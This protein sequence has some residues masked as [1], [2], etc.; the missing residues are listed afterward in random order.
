[1]VSA[2]LSLCCAVLGAFWV[3]G[4]LIKSKGSVTDV[5][6][7]LWAKP[8][9]RTPFT[10]LFAASGELQ[11][12]SF[13]LLCVVGYF[14]VSVVKASVSPPPLLG[15]DLPITIVF[16][17]TLIFVL[18]NSQNTMLTFGSAVQRLS[19]PDTVEA[20]SCIVFAADSTSH[21]AYV[22]GRKRPA[23]L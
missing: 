19:Q 1:M 4:S 6:A 17:I 3:S 22:F 15:I 12:V 2:L 20:H 11:F 7:L 21:L 5:L 8:G 14:T 18:I 9:S 13:A 23:R 16:A 10:V